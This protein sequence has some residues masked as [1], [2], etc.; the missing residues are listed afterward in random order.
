MDAYESVWLQS[1]RHFKIR[2]R[3][4]A[5]QPQPWRHVDTDFRSQSCSQ[6]IPQH[7]A[8]GEA[9]APAR[10]SWADGATAASLRSMH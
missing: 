10:A 3:R 2:H 5:L 8:C 9:P 7:N 1:L 6:S 4:L